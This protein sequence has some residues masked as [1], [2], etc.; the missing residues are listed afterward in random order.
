[1]SKGAD[2]KRLKS[3]GCVII[4]VCSFARDEKCTQCI[5]VS[6]ALVCMERLALRRVGTVAVAVNFDG[7]D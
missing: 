2:G 1:M 3:W 5:P 6:E 7:S 4:S